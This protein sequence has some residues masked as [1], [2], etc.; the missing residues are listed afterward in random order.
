[1]EFNDIR[2]TQQSAFFW[3]QWR[4]VDWKATSAW[5]H[6]PKSL[7]NQF[8]F[9]Q[10]CE[11]VA[12]KQGANLHMLFEMHVISKRSIMSVSSVLYSDIRLWQGHWAA[13]VFYAN[14]ENPLK[15]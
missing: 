12:V 6:A 15:G 4:E 13:E 5:G 3:W 11:A 14:G 10:N 2:H 9:E 1:M 8:F 7:Y